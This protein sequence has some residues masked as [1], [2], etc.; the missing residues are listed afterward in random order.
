MLNKIFLFFLLGVGSHLSVE[1]QP[2]NFQTKDSRFYERQAIKAYQA[3]DFP[4]FLENMKAAENLRPNHP[5]LLYNLAVADTLNGKT[6]E[7]IQNLTK[8]AKMQLVYQVEKDD[9]FAALKNNPE[10]QE[11]TKQFQFNSL[12]TR[13]S[14]LAFIVPEKGLVTESI[15]FD[16]ATRIF[17][18]SSVAHRKILSVNERGE[19]K[20]FADQ[21]TGLWSVFGIKVDA[22]RQLLWAA[23]SAHKQMANV[24]LGENGKAG[25]FAFDLKSGKPVKK[26]FLI[27]GNQPHL[28]GDLAIAPNGDVYATDSNAPNIFVV[29]QGKNEIETFL[30]SKLFASP[31]GLD[32]SPDGKFLFVADYSNGLFRINL[33]TKQIITLAPILNSTMLG[34]DG[35]YFTQNSL[36]G[37]QNGVNPQRVIQIFLSKSLDKIEDFKV[38]EANNPLFDEITLGVLV[39]KQFYFI[40]NSQWNLLGEN[41]GFSAPEKLKDVNILKIALKQ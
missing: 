5:R 15:G 8:L 40:A 24:K 13:M 37:I 23:T 33:K 18:L 20:V 2:I 12:P 10:F 14:E 38:I 17:Y 3:K 35:I 21:T 4:A 31:Q 25:I 19:A 27:D 26:L 28:L 36:I 16:S 9:D 41:G 7:A 1:V 6:S 34:I 22:K 39:N 32:F 29:R 11:L 30:T